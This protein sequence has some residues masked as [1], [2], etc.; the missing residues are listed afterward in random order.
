M[1]ALVHFL[2][3]VLRYPKKS[4]TRTMLFAESVLVVQDQVFVLKCFLEAVQN[5]IFS[6]V[7]RKSKSENRRRNHL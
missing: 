1:V 3:T 7:R 5:Y 2:G 6:Y 4:V